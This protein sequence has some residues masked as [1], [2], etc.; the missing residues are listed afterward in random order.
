MNVYI[1]LESLGNYGNKLD[2][3]VV[4]SSST[5]QPTNALFDGCQYFFLPWGSSKPCVVV[6]CSFED[7]SWRLETLNVLQRMV[8]E[9]VSRQDQSNNLTA[10]VSFLSFR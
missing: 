7:I 4:P 2:E 9:L 6:E 10:L 3:N 1:E 8:T 5:T